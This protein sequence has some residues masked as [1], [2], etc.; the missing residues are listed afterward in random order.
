MNGSSLIQKMAAKTEFWFSHFYTM[1]RKVDELH[2]LELLELLFSWP[3]TKSTFSIFQSAHQ[4][5]KFDASPIQ[6]FPHFKAT[7]N[8][9]I[10]LN[11]EIP[12]KYIRKVNEI[13]KSLKFWSNCFLHFV[14]TNSPLQ[15]LEYHLAY[16]HI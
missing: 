10:F 6:N 13:L 16:C 11:L 9:S 15:N 14:L 3:C 4:N 2:K 1:E 7:R 12:S 5:S 8:S